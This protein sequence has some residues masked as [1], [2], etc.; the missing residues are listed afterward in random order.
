[1]MFR[2]Y[3]L[4]SAVSKANETV[5]LWKADKGLVE[6]SKDALA[7]PVELEGQ[8][9]GYVFHGEGR[10]LLDTIA[11]TASGAIGKSVE[12]NVRE[13]FLML[14]TAEEA[15]QHLCPACDED[16]KRMRY[17]NQQQFIDKAHNLLDRFLERGRI[18]SC[19][20]FSD[21]SGRI[22]AFKN[23][24]GRLDILLFNG[25]KLV[26]KAADMMFVSD[27]HR[28]ILKSPE[29]MILSNRGRLINIRK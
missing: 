18:H 14:G 24:A 29:H 16:I 21:G 2:D 10:L 7:I 13:P 17:E 22:F 23:E 4:G 3:Q 6:I 28:T 15:K 27:G 25:S 8:L 12:K 5:V 1:M 9:C 11:E 26:Y 19:H 20:H